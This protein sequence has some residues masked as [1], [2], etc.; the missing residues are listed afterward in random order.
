MAWNAA[1]IH[2]G[3]ARIFMGNGAEVLPVTGA[4]PSLVAHTNG[5]PS[6]PQT[7][8]TEVGYTEGEATFTY[9]A[10]KQEVTAEQAMGAVDAFV[11][12]EQCQLVFTAQER[13]Y[14]TL[15]FAFDN[16]G[17]A[18]ASGYDLFYGGNGTSLVNILTRGVILTSVRRDQPTK[19]EVLC[20]YKCYSIDGIQLRYGRTSKSIYQIT[21]KAIN[22]TTRNNGD[23]LFQFFREK[24]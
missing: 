18:Q 1:N 10:T 20:L 6:T 16:T 15:R 23:M 8:F 3:A 17:T 4:P 13:V 21:M 19:W 11:T 7:G 22:D 12:D 14:N 24:T 9:R 2:I 5:V